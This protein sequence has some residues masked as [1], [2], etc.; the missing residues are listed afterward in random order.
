[1][2]KKAKELD[3]SENLQWFLN[4]IRLKHRLSKK[5]HKAD[6]LATGAEEGRGKLRKAAERR[7]QPL[8]RRFPNGE[9]HMK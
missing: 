2:D 7:K 9:T 4:R 8:T 5:E 3:S 6:A 1:M